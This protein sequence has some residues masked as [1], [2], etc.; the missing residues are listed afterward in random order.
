[1]ETICLIFY[2]VKILNGFLYF[3]DIAASVSKLWIPSLKLPLQLLSPLLP[4]PGGSSSG[5]IMIRA[6]STATL[7]QLFWPSSGHCAV[8]TVTFMCQLF[9]LALCTRNS[10]DHFQHLLQTIYIHFLVYLLY[11][12]PSFGHLLVIIGSWLIRLFGDWYWII[13]REPLLFRGHVTQ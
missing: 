10:G 11:N 2:V 5:I 13:V 7:L 4:A 1:M 6:Q 12:R 8:V 9:C 3:V